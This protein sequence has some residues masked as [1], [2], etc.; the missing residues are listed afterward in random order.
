[1]H[2]TSTLIDFDQMYP[3]QEFFSNIIVWMLFAVGR[4]FG[5][6]TGDPCKYACA[7]WRATAKGFRA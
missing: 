1:M 3:S 6:A 5:W 2:C 4:H 7:K